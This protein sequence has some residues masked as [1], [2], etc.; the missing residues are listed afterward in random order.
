MRQKQHDR[1]IATATPEMEATMA[2]YIAAGSI[3]RA[4]TSTNL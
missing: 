4:A 3:R 1:V 2:L